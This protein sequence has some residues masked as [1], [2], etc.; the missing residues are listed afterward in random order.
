MSTCK[1][2]GFDF[3][4]GGL[5]P[6]VNPILTGYFCALDKDLNILGELDLKISP[7]EPYSKVEAG[8]LEVNKID[9]A[10]HVE[11]KNTVSRQEAGRRLEEFLSLYSKNA[12]SKPKP[13]GHNIHF[14]M[15]F[16]T[17]LISADTIKKKLHY[18][19]ICTK[20]ISDFFKEVG[21]LPQ[22]IGKLESL[23]QYFGIPKGELHT[24]KD[25]TLMMVAAYGKLMQMTKDMSK[26]G[27]S[28]SMDVLSMLEK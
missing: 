28:L 16:L 7:E 12:K 25:D 18:G 6:S 1:Y 5:D 24:A 9:L 8:A 10:K 3:E 23:V 13:L 22:E 4:T 11:D 2:I 14:D 19:V 21:V 27:S 20:V 17:Q 15:G 26:P